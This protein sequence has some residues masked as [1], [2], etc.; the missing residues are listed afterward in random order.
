MIIDL[1]LVISIS[2]FVIIA[3]QIIN[4]HFIIIYLQLLILN[5]LN[6]FIKIVLAI[7]NYRF[8]VFILF[9]NP[10]HLIITTAVIIYIYDLIIKSVIINL[11][12]MQTI[13]KYLE[14]IITC[15]LNRIQVLILS[16]SIA[17]S[18]CIFIIYVIITH[19]SI[20][21]LS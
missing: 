21:S 16:L 13:F 8:T 18:T 9:L 2:L 4:A 5:F 7:S 12:S 19:Q 10:L 1:L 11:Q 15:Q 3:S 20:Y 17:T 14:F 6:H